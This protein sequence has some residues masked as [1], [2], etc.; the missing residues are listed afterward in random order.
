MGFIVHD[1]LQMILAKIHQVL[2]QG[3]SPIDAIL[4]RLEHVGFHHHA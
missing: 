4:V 3:I 1:F 2:H